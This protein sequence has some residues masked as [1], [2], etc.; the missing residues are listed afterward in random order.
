MATMKTLKFPGSSNV[1]EMVDATARAGVASLHTTVGGLV[2]DTLSTSGK[3]ADAKATGDG[4][5]NL[6]DALSA[7]NSK[8]TINWTL[9]ETVNSQGGIN[10]NNYLARSQKIPCVPGDLFIRTGA[11]LDA[12]NKALVVYIA[13][14][15][16]NT[17]L[18]RT[19]LTGSATSKKVVIGDN[20]TYL[21]IV[22]G[23]YT[24]SGVVI[25]QSD[26]DTY[27]DYELWRE[28]T[29]RPDFDTYAVKSKYAFTGTDINDITDNSFVF[30]AEGT[31]NNP[32]ATGGYF[33]LTVQYSE[34]NTNAA[35]Q[36]AYRYDNGM[37]YY[38]RKVSG[39]WNRWYCNSAPANPSRKQ[40]Y[41]F[42]DSLM[43]GAVWQDQ[44]GGGHTVTQASKEYQIPTRIANAIGA[45]ETMH[46]Q[47]VGGSYFVGDGANTIMSAI[48]SV[49]MTGA[50]LITVAGGRNDSDNALGDKNSTVNDGT[51]CGAIKAIIEYI[52]TNYPKTQIV[53]IGVTPN[54]SDN[55]TVFTKVFT[56]GWSLNSFDEKVSELCAEYCVPYVN[57][58]GCTY[59]RH[60]ADFSGADGVY[61]HPNN[62]ESYLQMGNYI[63]G[64][65][66][67]YYRG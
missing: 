13:E 14:F 64:Q 12:N 53:W 6:K 34:S 21:Y 2:D 10:A 9:K 31:T 1:Y 56:G 45:A 25:T 43:Y 44:A 16:K 28:G 49:T 20:A 37:T 52:Q 61:S 46:N 67:Q 11:K 40:Y 19:E 42:G 32:T 62:E 54:T 15:N 50:G 30:S 66:A 3:A 35:M 23:R 4:I 58:K 17:F 24:S 27:F 55:S 57:W 29:S 63:A 65:V 41:A 51:I 59:M 48:Q 8:I 60:W 47:S 5:N 26:I 33:V 7:V 38:R 22:F 18:R 36:I 39:S